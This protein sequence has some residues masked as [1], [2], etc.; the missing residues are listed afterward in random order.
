[1]S[2]PEHAGI[3]RNG[4]AK[5]SLE[6][7]A[8]IRHLPAAAFIAALTAALGLALAPLSATAQ[9]GDWPVYE[10]PTL[11][12][13][14]RYPADVFVAQPDNAMVDGRL[15]VSRDG[16]AKL[17]V[18]AF[19]NGDG[20]SLKAYRSFVIR[21]TYAK[22]TFDYA[23][24]RKTWFVLSGTRGNET[25]YQRVAFVC[26]GRTINSW[27]MIY[28]TEEKDLYDRIVERVHKTYMPSAGPGGACEM[29]R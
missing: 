21:E 26:G 27:A 2:E 9:S 8:M 24:V 10:H 23:P 1:M 3:G 4:I 12:F 29:S 18:G 14:L 15:F 5:F 17:A 25:F 20:M 13:S 16:R 6:S 11:G 7:T 22:A 28:P 19:A